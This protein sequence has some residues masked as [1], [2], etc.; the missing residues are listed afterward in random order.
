M[1]MH[2][3]IKI[4]HTVLE[5]GPVSL[6]QNSDLCKASTEWDSVIPWASSCQYQYVS[7]F[8]QTILYGSGVM[9]NFLKLTADGH[10]LQTDRGRTHRLIKDR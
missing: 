3:F 4:F 5:I 10:R 1:R 2:N 7:E 6:F 8:Y 9:D